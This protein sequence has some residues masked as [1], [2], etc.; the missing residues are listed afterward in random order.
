MIQ[1]F[2]PMDN[3]GTPLTNEYHCPLVSL[4]DLFV[5]CHHIPFYH[6]CTV[7]HVTT[8]THDQVEQLSVI[9]QKPMFV[10]DYM[11]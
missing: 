11:Q 9:S 5:V 4:T 7:K 1:L 6:A 8:T 2:E 10:H 3:F